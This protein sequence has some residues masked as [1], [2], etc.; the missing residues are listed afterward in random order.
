MKN[1]LIALVVILIIVFIGGFIFYSNSAKTSSSTNSSTNEQK[2]QTTESATAYT[3]SDV[4]KHNNQSSCWMAIDGKVYDFTS[5]IP[6]HP[7]TD[8]VDG[9][10]KDATSMYNEVRK[11]QGKAD[12]M[13]PDYLIGELAN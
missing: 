2:K 13:L 11:H 6:Q 1:K 8:I 7:N 9:C 3:L 4:A 12:S 10:G 5:Y